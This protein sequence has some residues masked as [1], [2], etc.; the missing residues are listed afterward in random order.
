[1]L[2]VIDNTTGIVREVEH[3]DP[4]SIASISTLLGPQYH[5]QR[6]GVVRPGVM[7]LK[8]GC[9]EVDR[10][11]YEEMIAAGYSWEDI[12][13]KLGKDSNGKSK[14]RPSN[15]DYF[16]VYKKD[17]INPENADAIMKYADPDGKLR[18]FPVWFPVNEWWNILPHSLRCFGA[19]GI[20]FKS[21]FVGNYDEA[22]RLM[23]MTRVCKFPMSAEKDKR[24]FG[25]R[26]WGTRPCDPSSCAEYQCG[27]CSFG[28]LI[29][30]CVPGTRG[31]GV[32][33]LPTISWYSM[34]NIKSTLEMVARLTGG[35]I[36]GLFNGKPI[37]RIMKKLD[38]VSR[39]DP[40]TGNSVKIKQWIIHLDADI[41]MTELAAYSET[42]KT[43][44]RA[45]NAVA[46]LN[47]SAVH[48]EVSKASQSPQ[49]VE[50][51]AP[52]EEMDVPVLLDNKDAQTDSDVQYPK[53]ADVAAETGGDYQ[54]HQDNEEPAIQ[55]QKDAIRKMALKH[56][57]DEA[58]IN[59][60]LDGISKEKA[61]A[62]IT[63]LNKGDK[64][65]FYEKPF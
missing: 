27:D 17:C 44:S 53:T 42:S 57:V 38:T 58:T 59:R 60:V 32:W 22:G 51:V 45:S 47:G 15:V 31:I 52:P 8:Q 3:G 62:Y 5:M 54:Q 25:G 6:L 18:S 35:K 9:S 30:F 39:I 7:I 34:V 65:M 23:N 49:P 48:V 10:K 12:E 1:M 21:D 40:A 2:E 43:E 41:D 50:V 29:H 14:L 4:E 64:A 46:L 61:R 26:Q 55:S 63:R 37:F 56:G 24:I 16:T 11:I 13:K 19:G 36:A 28:G 33:I 20:K